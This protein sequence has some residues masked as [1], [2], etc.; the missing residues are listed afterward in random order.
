MSPRLIIDGPLEYVDK[1]SAVRFLD[2]YIQVARTLRFKR[3]CLKLWSSGIIMGF[4]NRA[5]C[6]QVM[7][8]QEKGTFMIRFSETQAGL[9][10]ITYATGHEDKKVLHYLVTMDDIGHN[11]SLPEFLRRT[12][13]LTHVL[14]LNVESGELTRVPKDDCLSAYYAKKGRTKR[15]VEGYVSDIDMP[16]S[17][18]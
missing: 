3:H 16:L 14:K 8:A 5:K 18:E 6:E 4:V 12:N 2:W 15:D 10:S 9:F 7:S 1:P 11:R 13:L 17:N